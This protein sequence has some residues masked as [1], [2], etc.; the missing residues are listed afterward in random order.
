MQ[1]VNRSSN[2]AAVCHVVMNPVAG[3]A[4]PDRLALA[5][6][7]SLPSWPVT[8]HAPST[9]SEMRSLIR[10]VAHNED[11]VI[12][13]GDGTLQCALPALMETAHPFVVLPLGTAN[14]FARQWGYKAD[15]YSVHKALTQGT[16]R[17][18]D[19]VQCNDVPFLTVGGLGVGALLTRDFNWLR[20]RS[21]ALKRALESMGP[22]IY[23]AMAAATI[24]GRR[25]Y[26]RELEIEARGSVFSGLFSNV[27]ICNQQKLGGQLCVA[28]LANSS[29]GIVEILCLRGETPSELIHSL[30]CLRMSKEPQLSERISGKEVTLRA[31]DGKPILMFADGESYIL[32]P[33][34]KMTVHKRAISLLTESDVAA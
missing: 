6:R 1:S 15:V 12:A 27:F 2:S 32:A 33:E 18:V 16:L 30:A 17:Q 24:V 13:G 28:P 19:V 23:T 20:Q 21:P 10:S 4:H 9:P 14:D 11:L 25:S 22:E 5:L 31:A 3:R 34:I 8:L 7:N 29:D 26:L